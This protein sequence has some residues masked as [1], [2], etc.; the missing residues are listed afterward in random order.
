ML[1]RVKKIWGDRGNQSQYARWLFSYS[2][3]YLGKI[4]LVVVLGVLNT[5]ASLAM[6]Q[7]S[8]SII[9]NATFGNEFVRL[10]VIY[11][12]LVFGM[13]ALSVVNS[14]L[15]ALLTE[16]FSFGIRKQIYDKI[17]QSHWMDV[18]KYHTGDLMTRL[19][20]DAGNI[21]DGIISTIPGIFLLVIELV[22]VFFTLFQYSRLLAVLALLVAPVAAFTSCLLGRKLKVLQGK[23]QESEAAYRSFLQESLANLLIVKAFANEKYSVDRLTRLR[24]ER[25][26]WVFRRTK[27]SLFSS[28]TMSISFQIG[29]IAAFSYGVFQIANGSITYGTMSVFLALVNRVQAPVLQLAQQIPRIVMIL[30]SAGRVMELQDIPVEEKQP[31]QMKPEGIGVR[32]EGLSFGYTAETVLEDTALE[33]RPGEF[34][35]IIGESGIGKTTLIRLMMSFMSNYRGNITYFN[36]AG[37]QEKANA[38][39]RE[40]IAYVPQGNTLFSG[41]IRENIRMGNLEAS[42]EEI[43]Q[44]LRMAA[45]YDF[46][47]ELPEGLDTI[48]GER[49]HGLSEGQAQRIAIARAFVRRAPFLILDEAT[50]ALDEK[51]EL[52]VLQGLQ[53]LQ[54]KP[55]CLIITHRRS[56][57]TYCDREIRIQ[58]KRILEQEDGNIKNREKI[59]IKKD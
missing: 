21:A 1:E 7:V 2:R 26:K 4:G 6:V 20:S 39:S 51:T 43:F 35:A 19:T 16:K 54:P 53:E 3:P 32:V 50:S 46:V 37:E 42:E 22:M 41:T 57:L 44:A 17:I 30:T 12:L 9:D 40:F 28:T 49:G 8:K 15:T 38:G 58:D 11:M 29:Y 24:E 13:Q 18:K 25:F 34:V 56:I 59:E 14:L 47:M 27:M 5:V 52:S 36:Q 23:V 31:E 55:T 45:A 33:I 10:L 48:I